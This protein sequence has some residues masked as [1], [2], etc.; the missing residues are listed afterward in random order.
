[1]EL[2]VNEKISI[3]AEGKYCFTVIE[4]GIVKDEKSKNYGKPTTKELSFSSNFPDAV[5]SMVNK[6]IALS[7]D[8][9]QI[10]FLFGQIEAWSKTVKVIE[11]GKE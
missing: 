4:H 8:I 2:K 6:G 1:M 10:M 11:I 3:V 5:K 9:N 7:D